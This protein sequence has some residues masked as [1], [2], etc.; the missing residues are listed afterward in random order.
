MR[1]GFVSGRLWNDRKRFSW[2]GAA[3]PGAET[4]PL[5]RGRGDQPRRFRIVWLATGPGLLTR[6]FVQEMLQAENGVATALNAVAVLDRCGLYRAVAIHCFAAYKQTSRHW[7][8]AV[9]SRRSRNLPLAAN[10]TRGL[11]RSS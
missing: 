5:Y 3:P 6:A 2:C 8:N 7:S 4:G 11:A 9:F 1:T 10:P